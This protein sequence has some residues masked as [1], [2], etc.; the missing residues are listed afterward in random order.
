[1]DFNAKFI[2][3]KKQFE[4]AEISYKEQDFAMALP[5]L[6]EVRDKLI[7][8]T[9]YKKLSEDL[10]KKAGELLRTVRGYLKEMKRLNS[11]FKNNY[12][13]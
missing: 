7:E 6:L 4:F 13:V 11:E 12:G 3:I 8:L 5:E 9:S 1:M 10:Q 2:A